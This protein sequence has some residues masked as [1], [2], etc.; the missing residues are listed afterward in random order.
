MF[1]RHLGRR[2]NIDRGLEIAIQNC[3]ERRFDGWG[4]RPTEVQWDTGRKNRH[5]STP[6]SF[7]ALKRTV[8]ISERGW[9]QW[10][11][12]RIYARRRYI[13]YSFRCAFAK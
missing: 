12:V 11:L 7:Q 10:V 2:V 13:K 4:T 3:V 9:V 5:N 1:I 8:H 6:G